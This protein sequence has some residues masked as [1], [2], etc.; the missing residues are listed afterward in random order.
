MAD[1][2]LKE[3]EK[4]FES[5]QV[6]RPLSLAVQHGEFIVFVGPSGCGKSTLLRLIAGLEAVTGGDIFVAGR[7]VTTLPP[8]QRNVAMVFQ[9]YALYPHMT[10]EDNIGFGLKISRVPP[11]NRKQRVL[12]VAR[13]LQL[14]TLLSRKPRALSGG[15]RQRVAIGR[16]IVKEP[17]LFLF[18]EPLSNLDAELRVNTRLEL[19]KLHQALGATIVYV[20]HDQVEAMTLAD[21]IVVLRD[22]A[23]EQIGAP[24][25]IYLNPDNQFVAG[26]IGS[27]KMNFLD[28]R[29]TASHG[30]DTTVEIPTLGPGSFAI[31]TC[32]SPPVP[33]SPVTVGFRPEHLRGVNSEHGIKARIVLIEQLGSVS[34]AYLET[35]AGARVIAERRSEARERP[36]D[37]I[38][39]TLLPTGT[40]AFSKSGAR[41]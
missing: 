40:Y 3:V 34:Y 23:I 30:T 31:S 26:F 29:V 16:A 13:I 41:L 6:I 39:L 35:E 7:C 20:T 17:Q 36:G 19:A 14:E 33:G 28:A 15:Q 9:N 24:M 4:R 38:S 22:G 10:V 21:R 5:V 32:R 2:V 12:E 11:K 37:S 18:D 1:L 27:P 8:A 25:D